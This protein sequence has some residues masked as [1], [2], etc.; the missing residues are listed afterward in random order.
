MNQD[1]KILLAGYTGLVGSAILRKLQAMEYSQ[2]IRRDVQDI[3]FTRQ[4]D[5]EQF[6]A[7]EKPEYIF[8]AAA[9]VGGIVA[10]ASFPAEFIRDNL[11]I[12]SNIIDAA[13]KNGCKKLLFLGSSC[14]YPKFAPQPM[15]ES[16]LLT[17]ILEPTNEWYAIAKIAGLKMVQAYRRQYGFSGISLMPTNLYGYNDNFNLRSSHVLP[18]LIR[19]FHEAKCND[20]QSVTLWGSGNPRREFLFV[21]DLAD[22][23]VYLMNNYDGEEIVNVGVG[24]DIT[25]LELAEKIAAIV[26]CKAKIEF[27]S[28]QPDGTPQKLLDVTFLS[29]LGWQAKTSLDEG[30]RKTYK[31]YCEHE[32][33]LL[34]KEKF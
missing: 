26:G 17:G 33:E 6:F 9:K 5:T 7:E 21:D 20:S 25:I 16:C 23:A 10:N 32:A 11:M 8:L 14:I 12:Q 13:Y 34:N 18:A 31:W 30:L 24:K 2:I 4:A 28:S 1:S 19:K 3:D 29:K 15:P 27:D 22:A